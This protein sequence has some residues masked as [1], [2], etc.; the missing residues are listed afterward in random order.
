MR[1]QVLGLSTTKWDAGL[2]HLRMPALLAYEYVSAV[3]AHCT[4]LHC[5]TPLHQTL[6]HR[7]C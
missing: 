3:S 4:V 6:L 2:S 5:H 7:A 1:V